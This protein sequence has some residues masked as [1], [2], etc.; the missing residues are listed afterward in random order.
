MSV[1][2]AVK[3]ANRP[4]PAEHSIVLRVACAGAVVTGIAACRAEG[5]LSWTVAGGS[6]TMVVVGMVLA[7]RTRERPLP[8]IKPVLAAAA[9][10]A[11]VWFFRQLTGQTIYDVSTVENPLA[12]LFVWVQVSHSFDVPAR[13]DLAFSLAGSA[14]LMA[15]AAA[16]AIDIAFGVYVLTWFA[17]GLAGLL[18]MWSSASDGGRL[19]PRGLVATFAAV[20][21]A[22][23]AVLVV[24]PAPHVAGRIDFPAN[25]GPG[26]PVPVAGGLTGDA[27]VAQLAK[28]GN[29][30]G[31][32]RVGG[33]LGFANRLDTALRGG[34]GDTVVMRVR[35]DRP[36]YWIGETFDSWDGANWNSTASVHSPQRLDEGSPFTIPGPS[37]TPDAAQTD[38][39]T[40]YVVQPSPNLVFHA[41][42]ARQVW[43]PATN[44]FYAADDSIVSPI[45]LGSGAIYTVQSNVS[46]PTADQMRAAAG[47]V[48]D[49]ASV[50]KRY[51]QLPGTYPY[52]R[53]RTLAEAVT[54]HTPTTYGKVESLIAWIG[55]HTHYSTDIPPLAP[56]QDTVDEFLFG[57]RTGF[58]EQISTALAVMLRSVGIPAREAVGYVP[59]PYNPITDLYDVQAQDAHAWVQVWFPG[60][61]WQ[62][63]DPTA[64]VPLANPSPGSTLLHEASGAL[65]RLPWVPIGLVLATTSVVMM[66]GVWRRRRPGTWAEKA[67]RSI[68]IAG[69]RA[70]QRR[71]PDETL[72]EYA[73]AIDRVAG[74]PSATWQALAAV[75]EASAYGGRH[76]EPD[77]D[78]RLLAS[79]RAQRRELPRA[80]ALARWQARHAAPHAPA[81]G[82]ANRSAGPDVLVA[83]GALR[84]AGAPA[85]RR[86]SPP[87]PTGGGTPSAGGDG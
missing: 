1:L 61:G 50:Q 70:G 77:D 18:A 9:V 57:N 45:G 28:P 69:R 20:I 62:S 54:A 59:G 73:T 30:T 42:S 60:Y 48:A 80:G 81:P 5:E 33:Y 24:L 87:P 31:L 65:G 14:S 56:G 34:L 66:I 32:T 36:S 41:D 38:L 67:A 49:P 79:M 53:A 8:W 68:E 43:F 17:F 85:P 63:F 44:L 3:R 16:Q 19:H 29:R 4:G 15:V 7:Y 13:R 75:V 11:F 10:V 58:C 64:V 2:A 83:P 25:T 84:P 21:V 74:D 51:T 37:V 46:V 52:T 78:R 35:A 55:K 86:S 22:G 47:P 40:F 26:S 27:A 39:Q 76:P 12:V 23:T 71:R 72:T 82:E 6:I